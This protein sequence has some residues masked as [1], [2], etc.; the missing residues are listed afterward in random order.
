MRKMLGGV[1]LLTVLAISSLAAPLPANE[2][3]T[4]KRTV[5]APRYDATKEITISGTVQSLA[6]TP[7]P[8]RLMGAHLMVS[9]SN[10]TV[11]AHVGNLVQSGSHATSFAAGRA[12]KLVGVM[13]TVN[14][15]SVFLTREIQTANGTIEVR[16]EHGFLIN[17]SAKTR[18]TRISSAGGAR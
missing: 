17:P 10:G 12:V 7:T 18:S 3:A 16:N 8:G 15:K 1:C 6:T 9:T 4:F 11:D 13:T 5:V 14:N 2:T